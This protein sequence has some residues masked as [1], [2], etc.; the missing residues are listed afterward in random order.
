MFRVYNPC[1]VI[2]PTSPITLA[3]TSLESYLSTFQLQADMHPGSFFF[4]LWIT[5]GIEANIFV[6][7]EHIQRFDFIRGKAS[8]NLSKALRS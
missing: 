6:G 1:L 2:I 5:R 4:V 7:H 8:L 3:S